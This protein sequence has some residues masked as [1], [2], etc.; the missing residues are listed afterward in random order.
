MGW[1]T[2]RIGDPVAMRA[3]M[4]SLGDDIRRARLAGRLSAQAQVYVVTEAD[5][6]AFHYNEEALRVCPSLQ[7][8]GVLADRP[9]HA[10]ERINPLIEQAGDGYVPA[11]PRG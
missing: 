9:P 4:D 11:P 8:C 5:N 1:Y 3:L 2:A 7:H 10:S 6:V